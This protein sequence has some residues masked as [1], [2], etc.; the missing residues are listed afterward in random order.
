MS[1]AIEFL[2]KKWFELARQENYPNTPDVTQQLDDLGKE[3][4]ILKKIKF[5][6]NKG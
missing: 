1:I 2:K 5:A 6:R 3:I 4:N